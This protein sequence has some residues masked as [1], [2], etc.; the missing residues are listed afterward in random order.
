MTLIVLLTLLCLLAVPAVAQVIPFGV[1]AHLGGGEELRD[2]EQELQMMQQA[3]IRW[4]RADF[5]W[6][7]FEPQNDQWRLEAYDTIVAA[8][9][10]HEVNLLPILCYNVDWA[11]P[12]HEHLEDWCDYVRTVVGCYKNDLKYWEVWNEPNIG[13]WKPEP[14]PEQ[15]AS[16]LIATYKAIKETD[17]EAQVVY[18]GTAGVPL[19]FIR[20]TFE[21][22]AFDFFDVLAVH[23]YRYPTAPEEGGIDRDLRQTWEL[24]EEFGGGKRLWITEFGWPTHIA[25][26]LEEAAFLPQ[27]IR[28]SAGLRFPGRDAFKAAVLHEEGVPGCGDVG[29]LV[30][31]ALDRRPDVSS[32]L[33]GL[34]ELAGLDPADTQILVM[35]TGEAYPADYFDAML[36]FVRRGGLLVHLGGVPFYYASRSRDGKWESPTAGEDARRALHVGWKAWWTQEGLPEEAPTTKLAAPEDSGIRVPAGVKSTRWLTDAN[37]QGQD[38]FVPLLEAYRGEDQI[39][40]PVAL[41]LYDSDLKGAFLGTALSA[42]QTGVKE[43][44]QALYLPRALLLTLGEGV[45]NVLWYE[46]RDGGDDA[47]YNEHRFGV[48]HHDLTPKPAYQS[49]QTLTRALGQ[50]KFLEKLD[51]GEGTYCYVFDADDSKT[52]AVWRPAGTARVRLKVAGADLAVLDYQGAAVGHALAGGEIEVEAGEKVTYVTGLSDVRVP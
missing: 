14:N 36:D 13:F 10:A 34:G 4:A 45:E 18:G 48:I 19:D 2:H 23:P 40:H 37:L 38:R 52:V 21:A 50:G 22:G 6:G 39:G 32:R 20:K 49:Y 28:Y 47:A 3:G 51:V 1:C 9:Q 41:Y 26:V 35:P 7:Y 43:D 29:A 16:L 30:N 17:P 25:P 46:F 12:A 42:A 11:F 24:L 8:A 15:Y 33:V 5:T 31:E 27:L 44:K